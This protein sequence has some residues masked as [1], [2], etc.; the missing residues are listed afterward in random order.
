ML[1]SPTKSDSVGVVFTS[2]TGSVGSVTGMFTHGSSVFVNSPSPVGLSLPDVDS[3]SVPEPLFDE[4]LVPEL[5]LDSLPVF[6]VVP[7]ELTRVPLPKPSVCDSPV[8]SGVEVES[9][10][11]LVSPEDTTP[12]VVVA[13]VPS[14]GV[15]DVAGGRLAVCTDPFDPDDCCPPLDPSPLPPLLPPWDGDQ[16]CPPLG[17]PEDDPWLL[18]P[19]DPVP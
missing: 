6:E 8:D 1:S 11:E 10:V 7:E 9:G 16:P 5:P 13:G 15:A 3:L 19:P 18:P 12:V 4:L 17:D 2:S 14:T